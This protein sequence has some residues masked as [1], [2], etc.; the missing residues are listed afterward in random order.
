MKTITVLGTLDI[1]KVGDRGRI[2]VEQQGP[3]TIPYIE[4]QARN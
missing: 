3:R 1:E 2:A 4:H